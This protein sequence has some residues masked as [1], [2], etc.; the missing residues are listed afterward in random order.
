MLR[1][2]SA[3]S[4]RS[5]RSVGENPCSQFVTAALEALMRFS[6]SALWYECAHSARFPNKSKLKC[7]WLENGLRRRTNCGY[8]NTNQKARYGRGFL[9]WHCERREERGTAAG[10]S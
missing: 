5:S 4:R 7:D 9:Q 1:S 6:L 3:T 10:A 2:A 8:D